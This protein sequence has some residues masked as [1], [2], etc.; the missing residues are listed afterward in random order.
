MMQFGLYKF[1]CGFF[2]RIASR[3]GITIIK[4]NRELE[5][6]KTGLNF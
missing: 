5:Y 4:I 6:N 3:R 1:E 2:S